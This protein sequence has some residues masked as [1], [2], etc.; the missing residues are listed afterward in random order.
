MRKKMIVFIVLLAILFFRKELK[1][2]A[3]YVVEMGEVQIL[4]LDQCNTCFLVT[5]PPKNKELYF[6][7]DSFIKKQ[8]DTIQKKD[9]LSIRFSFFKEDA[10]LDRNYKFVEYDEWGWNWD[11]DDL[12]LHRENKIMEVS[13]YIAHGK[14]KHFDYYSKNPEGYNFYKYGIPTLGIKQPVWLIEGK[15][16]DTLSNEI[17]LRK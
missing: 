5:N 1:F 6:L 3:R 10:D 16:Y 14:Y 15:Y 9:T 2:Y 8:I 13:I 17:M 7:L 4:P 12:S 11:Y